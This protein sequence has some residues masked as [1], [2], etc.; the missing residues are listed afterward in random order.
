MK[1]VENSF[2]D[3]TDSVNK[4]IIEFQQQQKRP[5]NS[6]S[7]HTSELPITQL[8]NSAVE[9][10][11]E[12]DIEYFDSTCSE[13]HNKDDYIIISDKIYYRNV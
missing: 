4:L 10:F 8:D 13:S 6:S 1:G 5:L 9:R 11:K 7:L 12:S 2:I 3:L